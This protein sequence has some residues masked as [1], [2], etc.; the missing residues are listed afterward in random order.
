MKTKQ[1]TTLILTLVMVSVASVVGA[2][3][4]SR[5]DRAECFG[6]YSPGACIV[7]SCSIEETKICEC[8]SDGTWSC[9]QAACGSAPS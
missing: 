9:C 6:G 2:F 4:G 7:G 8:Q 5:P 3:G 1:L